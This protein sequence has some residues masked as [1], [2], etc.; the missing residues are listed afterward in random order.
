MNQIAKEKRN[1]QKQ[2]LHAM[3]IEQL[4][5]DEIKTT[6]QKAVI[7][8]LEN[9]EN[10]ILNRTIFVT[11]I[12]DIRV[13]SNL[14][15]LQT[16]FERNFGPVEQCCITSFQ[17]K[18][19]PNHN[20]RNNRSN[21]PPPAKV[22]FR[23][24]QSAIKVFGMP[25]DEARNGGSKSAM[26]LISAQGVAYNGKQNA[27]KLK[28][29]LAV[30]R[31]K[32]MPIT[33]E[34][35]YGLSKTLE[36]S[37]ISLGHWI[38]EDSGLLFLKGAP[39]E[40]G[41]YEDE[42]EFL[43]EYSGFQGSQMK[44]DLRQRLIQIRATVDLSGSFLFNLFNE[45]FNTITFRL[46]DIDTYLDLAY[47]ESSDTHCLVFGCKEPPK[48]YKVEVFNEL[49]YCYE[50]STRLTGL[51]D[52]PF[53]HCFGFKISFEQSQLKMLFNNHDKFHCRLQ[54]FGI[55]RAKCFDDCIT[56]STKKI[57]YGLK[58]RNDMAHGITS[59]PNEKLRK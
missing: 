43:E 41:K 53:D 16:F 11:N 33:E 56:L 36:V 6:K 52:A 17:S 29:Y 57:S 32:K 50:K 1:F 45:Q 30:K 10:E 9:E 44:L 55:T 59:I 42:Y 20:L 51:E 39:I 27:G 14:K 35:V 37:S 13:G 49:G 26:K 7:E 2:N 5:N 48:L 34:D 28:V 15:A 8:T 58:E 31:I 22:T 23:S 12:K 24:V 4:L 25:L 47:D 18:R 21:P 40:I 46:K 38:P 3:A 54:D 19:K